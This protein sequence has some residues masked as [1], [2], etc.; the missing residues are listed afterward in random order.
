MLCAANRCGH[1][2][3]RQLER[4]RTEPVER[5]PVEPV[6]RHAPHTGAPFLARLGEQQRRA[7]VE[8]EPRLAVA[9]L[10]RQLVVDEQ[11]AALHQVHHEGDRLEPQQ[12]VLAA[13][14]D[15]DQ[16]QA[17]RGVGRRH[18]GLECGEVER[19]EPREEPA[20][21]LL[22]ESLG[23]GLHLGQ[24]GHVSS[25]ASTSDVLGALADDGEHRVERLEDGL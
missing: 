9:R 19:H 10:E 12:Q 4:L 20:A 18:G 1:L 24:L 6:A 5:G 16:R 25:S 21:E 11:P 2:L 13:P 3:V 23:V 8:H 17:V 22:G 7:L 15:L 14:A